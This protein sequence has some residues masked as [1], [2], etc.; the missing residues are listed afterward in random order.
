MSGREVRMD[1]EF[2]GVQLKQG[3][4]LIASTVLHGLDRRLHSSPMEVDF[5]RKRSVHM[6]F[7]AGPHMCPGANLARSELR[8]AL[9]EWLERIPE[10]V[11]APGGK[12]A[13][14]GGLTGALERLPLVW[15]T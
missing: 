5:D 13:F 12:V 2:G 9:E 10:F 7:G 11:L 15:P 1:I 8:I 14:S 3:D 6:T 4:V